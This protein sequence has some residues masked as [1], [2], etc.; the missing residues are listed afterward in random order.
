MTARRHLHIAALTALVLGSCSTSSST[1]EKKAGT[2][3]SA[4]PQQKEEKGT[5]RAPTPP[6]QA[7]TEPAKQQAKVEEQNSPVTV[8]RDTVMT[9]P[10]SITIGKQLTQAERAQVQ[11]ILDHSFDDINNTFNKWNPDSE[12]SKLNAM[13]AGRKVPISRRLER[14]LLECDQ[15]VRLTEGRFDPTMLP[16]QDLWQAKMEKGERPAQW[17]V[18]ELEAAVGWDKI[19]F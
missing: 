10:Y 17:E 2:A 3:A 4:A 1:E 13:K 12:L 16:L 7:P 11:T 18:E 15:L 5:A 19:E 8:L 14:F 6:P 9:V